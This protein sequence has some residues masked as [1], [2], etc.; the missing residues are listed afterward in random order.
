[1]FGPKDILSKST[2]N[3]G[4]I[5]LIKPVLDGIGIKGIVD[6]YAPMERERGITNGD[7]I[8]VMVLNRLTSPT[9]LYSV[10]EWARVHAL[11]EAFGIAPD[12]VNYD[13]LARALDAVSTKIEDIKADVSLRMMSKYHIKPEIV[14]LDASSLYFE[15]AYQDSDLVRLGYS[16]D[17]KPDKK[18]VN[19]A[20]DVDASEGMPLF[21]TVHNGNTPDPTMAVANLKRIRER[22]KPDRMTVVGDRSAMDGEVALMLRDYGLD[23]VG[24]VKMTEKTKELAASIPDE[25]FK[26][27]DVEDYGAAESTVQFSHDSR[28]MDSRG[29]VVLSRRK[30]EQD[31]KKRSEAISAIESEFVKIKAKL[32]TKRWSER[33]VVQ[34]RVDSILRKKSGYARLF[35][36]KV[37]GGHGSLSFTYSIDE[38]ELKSAS[39]LDGKYVLATTLNGWSAEKVFG[40]YRSRYLVEARIRNMKS[41]I[42][43][44]PIFL[45]D[46]ERI[47]AL[48]FVSILALMV[49]SL[50]ETLARRSGMERMTTR[51]LLFV[52]Q[53]ISVIE[54]KLRGGV[55]FRLVE[56][57]TAAQ[58]EILDRLKLRMP[59]SYIKTVVQ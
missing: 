15:G 35:K 51:Q 37:S 36:T 21:H 52:F 28:K 8:Q 6:G 49:Y 18:Q 16:R 9:P 14:H 58:G 43:V 41:E 25:E 44:R 33:D 5:S 26:P 4:A 46:E 13:R 50:I 59:A 56:D 38:D 17:Q 47:R 7:A 45:H 19:V 34:R 30:A 42:A 20:L 24:A 11:E 39:R 3:L 12:E 10:E 23:F 32:N 53:K 29:V 31:A 1:M 48:V 27:M 2:K 22:L 57:L 54:L 55:K 40:T